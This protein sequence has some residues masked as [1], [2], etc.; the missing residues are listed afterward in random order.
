M[1]AYRDLLPA[2]LLAAISPIFAGEA[3]YDVKDYGATGRQPD[4]ARLAIQKA[5]DAASAA[6]GG[7]V[8][9]PPGAYTSGTLHLRSHVRLLIDSGATLYASLDSRAFD[10]AAL[11]YGEDADNIT[12]EGRGTLDG[13]ASYQWQ[14]NGNFDDAYIRGNMLLA[15]AL[16]RSLGKPLMRSFPAGFPTEQMY[17]HLVLL[18]R[19]KDVRIAG[20]SFVRS[21]SWTINPYACER[22]TIDGVYIQSSLKEAVWAD[23]IDPDGCKDVHISNSTIETGDDAIVFYSSN[24]WGPP[25]PC[26]NITVTNCRLSSAS[27]AI[28]FCDGNMNCI[29]HVTV[30][31][32]VIRD[33]NRGIAFMVFDGGYVSDVVLS[34]LTIE[35]RRHDWFWWGDGD[36]IH[37]NI[38]RRS[39]VDGRPKANEPPA[40]SIR[41]VTIRNVVA[42]GMGTSMIHG[43][44]DSLLDGISLDNIKLF[45]SNDPAS[46]LQKTVDAMQIRWARNFKMRDIE[47]IWDK[48]V[49]AKWRSALRLEDAE[50]VDL[51]GFRGRPA[52]PDAAA[53]ALVNV[54][55][56]TLRNSNAA[57]GT[58]LYLDVAGAKS[59]G[60]RLMSNDLSGATIPYR[61]GS[62]AARDAVAH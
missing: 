27:S 31:N 57:A 61:V 40:G 60:I 4:N 23:G 28:K 26:E 47:V 3:V 10:K 44:P 12:I 51:D 29:R 16:A 11:I 62:G 17:P 9:L 50:D 37:F 53:I 25:L 8:Y 52:A 34:N 19:C 1:P 30:D 21:R 38:K 49:S 35:C 45:V 59:R 43:H 22:L 2:L 46:P 58:G 41:N 6:G 42:H 13:Q 5:I 36:P 24:I 56:V 18:L 15:R 32:T 39:E 33:S 7:T 20:L 54:N 48:P 14:D 55:G